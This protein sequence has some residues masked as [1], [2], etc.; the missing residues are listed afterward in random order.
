MA[1]INDITKMSIANG[2]G[3]FFNIMSCIYNAINKKATV[4]VPK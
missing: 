3:I 4:I 2:I 1:I